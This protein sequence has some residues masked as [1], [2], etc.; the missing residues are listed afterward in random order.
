VVKNVKL[1][2]IDLLRAASVSS[3]RCDNTDKLLI[4]WW[5]AVQ[6]EQARA[7]RQKKRGAEEEQAVHHDLPVEA[8]GE[9]DRLANERSR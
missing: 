7:K 4:V 9:L 3:A 2:V 1:S 8:A 6:L 5:A